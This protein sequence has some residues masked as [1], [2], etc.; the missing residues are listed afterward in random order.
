M[1][2]EAIRNIM[3][4]KVFP[5]ASQEVNIEN[6]INTSSIIQEILKQVE[7]YHPWI[8]KIQ[9]GGLDPKLVSCIRELKA[10]TDTNRDDLS[11][12]IA[13]LEDSKVS[14]DKITG[15]VNR[16]LE[17]LRNGTI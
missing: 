6:L 16:L 2:A 14:L 8:P 4:W 15:C 10:S 13:T 17:G 7:D 3:L 9:V 11:R 5:D 1:S 12:L